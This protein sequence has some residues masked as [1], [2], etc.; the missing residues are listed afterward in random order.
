MDWEDEVV[1]KHFMDYRKKVVLESGVDKKVVEDVFAKE[2]KDPRLTVTETVDLL[3]DAG[4]K[5]PE[6]LW[7]YSFLAI[8][9]VRIEKQ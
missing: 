7:V 6:V 4:F 9:R 3:R 2:E 5:T 1:S 8:F